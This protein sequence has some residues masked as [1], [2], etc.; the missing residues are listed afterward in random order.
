MGSGFNSNEG[1]GT[2]PNVWNGL[3]KNAVSCLMSAKA[4]GGNKAPS[5]KG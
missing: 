4:D 1:Y 3:K 5:R 2:S